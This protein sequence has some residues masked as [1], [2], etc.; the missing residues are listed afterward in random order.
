M[1]KILLS[2]FFAS[3]F[4]PFSILNGQQKKQTEKF[5]IL[6][7]SN[8]SKENLSI[9][10]YQNLIAYTKRKQP[11]NGTFYINEGIGSNNKHIIRLHNKN[12][13]QSSYYEF[14]DGKINFIILGKKDTYKYKRKTENAGY[15]QEFSYGITTQI[16]FYPNGLVHTI[17]HF[18][19]GAK[20]SGYPVGIWYAYSEDGALQQKIDH[21][22]HFRMNFYDLLAIGDSY[23]FPYISITRAFND[24]HSYWYVFVSPHHEDRE[25]KERTILIDDKTGQTIYNINRE[26]YDYLKPMIYDNMNISTSSLDWLR[27]NDKHQIPDQE[28]YKLF[29]GY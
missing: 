3:I 18:G 29:R 24:I 26:S 27:E 4:N 21:D 8:I 13:T 19:N 9:P 12:Y 6:K 22:P 2:I 23:G 28:I 1:Y 14:I 20:S 25:T 17:R 11:V 5:N 7:T 10:D 15:T 16:D